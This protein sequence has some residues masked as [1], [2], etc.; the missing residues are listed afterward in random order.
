MTID[1]LRALLEAWPQM[2]PRERER[3]SARLALECRGLFAAE[4]GAA[5]AEIAAEGHGALAAYAREVRVTR[6][7]LDDLLAAHLKR[8]AAGGRLPA[9]IPLSGLLTMHP[10]GGIVSDVREEQRKEPR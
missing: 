5:V 8:E 4:R 6:S 2:G 10:H 9:A 7:K 3:L 1:E